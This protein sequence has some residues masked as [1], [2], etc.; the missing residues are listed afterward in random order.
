MEEDSYATV[1]VERPGKSMVV[2]IGTWGLPTRQGDTGD[3]IGIIVGWI[4]EAWM[5]KYTGIKISLIIRRK[6]KSFLG[7]VVFQ[8]RHGDYDCAIRD[9][10]ATLAAARAGEYDDWDGE[11]KRQKFVCSCWNERR[12]AK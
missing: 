7:N 10:D 2:G 8:R 6:G 3:P 5:S 1:G 4:I 9:M 11:P 12:L